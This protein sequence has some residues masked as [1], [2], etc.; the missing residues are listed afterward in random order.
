MCIFYLPLAQAARPGE[1]CVPGGVLPPPL[2]QQADTEAGGAGA[3]G[4]LEADQ[5]HQPGVQPVAAHQV[6]AQAQPVHSV[7]LEQ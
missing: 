5:V 4:G 1:G 2:P 6:P 7:H 3:E